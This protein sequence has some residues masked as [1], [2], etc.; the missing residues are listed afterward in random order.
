MSGRGEIG[1]EMDKAYVESLATGEVIEVLDTRS[2]TGYIAAREA[3]RRDGAPLRIM[4]HHGKPVN[5]AR[6]DA[7][8]LVHDWYDWGGKRYVFVCDHM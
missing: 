4:W 2:Q 5:Q 7:G 8:E 1:C 3:A 6:V